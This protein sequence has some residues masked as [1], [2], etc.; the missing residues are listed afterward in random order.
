MIQYLLGSPITI[1]A[2]SA[3]VMNLFL[4]KTSKQTVKKAEPAEDSEAS[5][6]ATAG[7]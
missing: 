4:S 2:I 5:V 6:E 3:I 7:R 1:G